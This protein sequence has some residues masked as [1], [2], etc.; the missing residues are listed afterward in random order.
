MMRVLHFENVFGE[1]LGSCRLWECLLR[2]S[3]NFQDS[4]AFENSFEAFSRGIEALNRLCQR[5]H[6]SFS[7]NRNFN[8]LKNY[9]CMKNY[10]LGRIEALRYDF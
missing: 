1:I 9:C 2:T 10:F 7:I 4:N 3:M 5:S 8:A 6:T